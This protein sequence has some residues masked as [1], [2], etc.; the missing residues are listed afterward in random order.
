M[1]WAYTTPTLPPGSYRVN[2][3]GVYDAAGNKDTS[4]A[5]AT[6]VIQ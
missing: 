4:I 6:F 1:T 3:G 2:L 5:T